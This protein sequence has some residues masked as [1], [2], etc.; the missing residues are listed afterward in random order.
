M[1]KYILMGYLDLT[2]GIDAPVRH[3]FAF[4]LSDDG[5]AAFL[6]S[7]VLRDIGSGSFHLTIVCKPAWHEIRTI[8]AFDSLKVIGKGSLGKVIQN[9]KKDNQRIYSAF[10]I[11]TETLHCPEP[12]T[13]GPTTHLLSC[14]FTVNISAEYYICQ[15]E[16][17]VK[18]AASVSGAFITTVT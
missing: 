17:S 7:V 4:S 1:G 13:C 16:H 2:P 9:R 10:P 11:P 5:L 8:D 3:L 18:T 6:R 15:S 12:L 14:T